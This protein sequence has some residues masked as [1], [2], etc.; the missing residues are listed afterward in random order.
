MGT[1]KE[2]GRRSMAMTEAKDRDGWLALFA[3]DGSVEDPVGPSIFDPEGHGHR[4]IEGITA[5]YDNVIST[6]EKIRFDMRQAAECADECA[7]SGTIHI[8]LPGGKQGSVELINVYKV[9]GEGKIAS[10]RS[11]WEFGQLSFD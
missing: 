1:A 2:M 7:F 4:G 9:D 11:F 3:A 5:F 6:S 8:T 10:L